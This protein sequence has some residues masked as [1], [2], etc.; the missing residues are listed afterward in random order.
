M[1]VFVERSPDFQQSFENRT[2][3]VCPFRKELLVALLRLNGD[4]AAPR[5]TST[6][7]GRQVHGDNFCTQT[8]LPP[9]VVAF[10]VMYAA[11]FNYTGSPSITQPCGF[12][13]QNGLPLG[14]QFVGHHGG[15]ATLIQAAHAFEK[16]TGWHDLVPSAIK[17]GVK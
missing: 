17:E 4:N 1:D 2:V 7:Q 6:N 13:D 15:E 9:E 14:L 3:I 12:D 5:L 11:P 10:F 8:V 16:T